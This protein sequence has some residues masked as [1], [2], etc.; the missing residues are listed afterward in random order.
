MFR[1]VLSVSLVALAAAACAT[2]TQSSHLT[3]TPVQSRDSYYVKGHNAVAARAADSAGPSMLAGASSAGVVEWQT[4]GTQNALLERACGFKSRSRHVDP[5][6]SS[7][8]VSNDKGVTFN[9]VG[10]GL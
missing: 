4:R 2:T 3:V 10:C 5:V 9:P 6:G 7:T 1:T 8:S